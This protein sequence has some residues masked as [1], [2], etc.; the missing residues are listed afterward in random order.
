MINQC[1]KC[2]HKWNQRGKKIPKVCPRCKNPNWHKKNNKELMSL[3]VGD[4]L[5]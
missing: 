5:A 3:I 2:K 4:F 1:N